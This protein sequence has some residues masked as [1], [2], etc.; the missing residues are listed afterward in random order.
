MRQRVTGA[1]ALSCQPRLLIADEPTTS[2]DVTIQSQYLKLL[3][4]I[5]HETGIGIIF[6]THDFGVVAKMC[7]KVLVMYA[8][9]VVESAKTRDIF[10]NPCHP[11]TKALMSCM[12]KLE[13]K[14]DR[15]PNIEGQPPDLSDLTKGCSFA[16]R[17]PDKPKDAEG[18]KLCEQEYPRQIQV[19]VDHFVNCWLVR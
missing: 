10:N 17:C 6:V 7:D 16:P 2:L 5:Q 19:G 12:P 1:I 11:Y 13:A 18:I 4:D 9:K 8:G 14:S 3:K 15:L